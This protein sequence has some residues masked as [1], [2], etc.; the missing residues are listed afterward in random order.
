M[1]ALL[2]GLLITGPAWGQDVQL[3]ARVI[4]VQG[5]LLALDRGSLSGVA[6]SDRVQ[7]LPVVG[8]VLECTIQSVTERESWVRTDASGQIAPGT[9]AVIHIP[10]GR[11]DS[12]REPLDWDTDPIAWD[13]D[14]PLLAEWPSVTPEARPRKVR[15]R[16]YV[17]GE[18]ADDALYDQE[19]SLGR[20]GLNVEV[21]NAFGR[22]GTLEF[23]GEILLRSAHTD[24]SADLSESDLRV[25]RMSYVMDG[26]GGSGRRY[27]YGRF[28]Q[29]EV[30]EFGVLDGVQVVQRLGNSDLVGVSIGLMPQTHEDLATGEDVQV[31]TFYRHTRGSNEQFS[32]LGAYQKSWHRGQADRDLLLA[33][34]RWYPGEG[35]TAWSSAWI[36][37]YDSSDTL[38]GSGAE[39]T[40]WNAGLGKTFGRSGALHATISEFRFPELLRDAPPL[41]GAEDL[42]ED[43][44][45]RLSLSG[46]ARLSDRTRLSARADRWSDETHSGSGGELGLRV[47]DLG[48]E[49]DLL[50]IALTKQEGLYGDIA[51]VRSTYGRYGPRGGWGVTWETGTHETAGFFGEQASLDQDRL[52]LFFDRHTK[53]GWDLSLYAEQRTGDDRDSLLIGF[54]LQRGF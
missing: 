48:F 24:D 26:R 39:L 6:L 35:L 13:T 16:W 11:I 3:E 27:A 25:D 41:L 33:N 9:R 28:L 30:P 19:Y 23:D 51:G 46:W 4:Q 34:A 17:M 31:A 14:M 18:F 7:I 8:Q 21:E 37:L 38:K 50:T 40:R 32:L 44:T 49:D 45:R 5:D 53:A 2:L 15:G 22:G 20:A 1:R 29:A 52:R 10:K 12:E 42:A 54:Y 43:R 36:D 47:R